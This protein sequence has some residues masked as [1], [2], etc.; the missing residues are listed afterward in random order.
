MTDYFILMHPMN[1]MTAVHV[2]LNTQHTDP[3]DSKANNTID[4]EMLY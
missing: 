2:Y 3:I 4:M 1:R